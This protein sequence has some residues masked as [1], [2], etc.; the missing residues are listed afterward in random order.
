MQT[1]TLH[2]ERLQI[3]GM[4]CEGCTSIVTRSLV[5]IDGVHDV[6]VTLFTDVTQSIVRVQYDEQFTSPDK[7]K[8]AVQ[9]AGYG[10][11]DDSASEKSE[12]R[13]C[14]CKYVRENS[15][16]KSLVSKALLTQI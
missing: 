11:A 8:A 3:S 1:E 5:A 9:E 10:V 16:V 12:A 7:L 13:G 14:C 15:L 6:K 4:R 2:T